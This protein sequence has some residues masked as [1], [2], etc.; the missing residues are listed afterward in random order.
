M[1]GAERPPQTPLAQPLAPRTLLGSFTYADIAVAQV[2]VGVE[3][4]A[5]GLKM[6]PASRR[7][8][9]DPGLRADWADLVAWRDELYRTLRAPAR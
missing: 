4:P 7:A 2:L 9:T 3:P 8:F 5:S 6:R 1:G